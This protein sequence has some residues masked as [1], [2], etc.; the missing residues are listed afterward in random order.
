ME[1][2][3]NIMTLIILLIVFT[4]VLGQIILSILYSTPRSI[5]YF[6]KKELKAKAIVISILPAIIWSS[7]L[8]CA[9]VLL[10]NVS[11]WFSWY[12]LHIALTSWGIKAAFWIMLVIYAWEALFAAPESSTSLEYHQTVFMKHVTDQEKNRIDFGYAFIYDLSY[13]TLQAHY[14]EMVMY[15]KKLHPVDLIIIR[16]LLEEKKKEA[17]NK[18]EIA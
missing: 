16:R 11:Y 4:V 8:L 13:E 7:I 12:W 5:I 14:K 3:V 1:V 10:D 9:Y 15:N 17:K 2:F 18:A 6:F